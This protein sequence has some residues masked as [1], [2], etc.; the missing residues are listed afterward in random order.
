[1]FCVN[2]G[3][4]INDNARFCNFCGTSQEIEA[5][6]EVQQEKAPSYTFDFH[7][8]VVENG[9]EAH[10]EHL[11]NQDLDS[12][13]VLMSLTEADLEKLGIESIGAK[14]KILNGVQKLKTTA[15]TYTANKEV[16]NRSEIPNHCPNCGEFWGLQ[17][18]NSG[19]GNTLGKALLGGLVLGPIGAIG[20]AAFGNKSITYVCS[21]CGFKKEYKSSVVKNAA[22]G[23]KKIFK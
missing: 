1:M 23:I 6:N 20:G 3:K 2:C 11:K 8:W 22:Q 15:N 4:T 21:K 12:V 16:G 10:E 17:K 9:L 19:A 7:R 18:E 5:V 14:K 13:D